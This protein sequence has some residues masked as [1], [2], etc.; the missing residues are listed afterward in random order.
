MDLNHCT[1]EE[2]KRVIVACGG[3]TTGNS[4]A[5]KTDNGLLH[6]IDTS[7][8]RTIPQMLSTIADPNVIPDPSICSFADILLL[9][10][11]NDSKFQDSFDIISNTAP[12]LEPD[13]I[14]KEWVAVS[15]SNNSKCLPSAL[16]HIQEEN[17]RLWYYM[18]IS[19]SENRGLSGREA[20]MS[21]I[22]LV[23]LQLLVAST[24]LERD[25]HSLGQFVHVVHGYCTVCCTRTSLCYHK[26][27]VLFMQYHHWSEGRPP[28]PKSQSQ[29]V[30]VVCKCY[31]ASDKPIIQNNYPEFLRKLRKETAKIIGNEM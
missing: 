21:C 22:F 25:G 14:Q 6:K 23:L 29:L 10:L 2:L 28:T 4:G 9:R 24:T 15:H 3:N 18:M 1:N 16:M 20:K 11:F 7:K 5:T 8:W 26:A 30:I 19:W 27:L 31:R 13:L 17:E 12:E